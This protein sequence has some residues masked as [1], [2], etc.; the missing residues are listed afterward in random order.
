ML[1]SGG[2]GMK[3][4]LFFFLV[5]AG[6]LLTAPPMEYKSFRHPKG[7][8]SF[9]YPADWSV[10]PSASGDGVLVSPPENSGG[11]N[12]QIESVTVKKGKKACDYIAEDEA[13]AEIKK[14]NL[15]PEEKRIVAKEGLESL[16]AKEGCLAAY[17]VME[18]E[19]E[20]LQ[21][22]GIYSTGKH[23]WRLL[24]V[25]PVSYRETYAA[26]LSEIAGSFSLK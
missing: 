24:Q 4:G 10:I 13:Q 9:R 14:V 17:Q 1:A 18:G 21:G 3:S 6:N 22:V 16:G 11:T 5:L 20:V 25:L 15:I 23:V 26:P 19:V 7:K 2:S 12:V 8:F